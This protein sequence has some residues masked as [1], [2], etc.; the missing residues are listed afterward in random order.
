MTANGCAEHYPIWKTPVFIG[1]PLAN[2]ING[3]MTRDSSVNHDE[4]HYS[5]QKEGHDG[6]GICWAI[7]N[8]KYLLKIKLKEN[9]FYTIFHWQSFCR[10]NSTSKHN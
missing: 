4:R 10:F 1:G 9:N 8:E 5:A 7:Y 6:K 3:S 2:L